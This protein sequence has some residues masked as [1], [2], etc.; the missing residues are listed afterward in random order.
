MNNPPYQ[1]LEFNIELNKIKNEAILKA[2]FG[3][4]A[5]KDLYNI[6]LRAINFIP[7]PARGSIPLFEYKNP[8]TQEVVFMT[9]RDA[10]KTDFYRV[11]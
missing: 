2:L 8:H 9:Q 6:Y 7:H 5:E 1:R 4:P 10:A 11:R 3:N